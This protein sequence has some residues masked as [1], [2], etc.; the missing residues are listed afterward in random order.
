MVRSRHHKT[1]TA[2]RYLPV[3]YKA[4][5]CDPQTGSVLSCYQQ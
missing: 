3:R 4:T 5:Q 1:A 2:L